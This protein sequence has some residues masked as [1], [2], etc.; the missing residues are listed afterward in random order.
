MTSIL[1]IGCGKMGGALLRGWMQ[2]NPATKVQVIESDTALAQHIQ[3]DISLPV[4]FALRD[5]PADYRPDV[6]VIAFKPQSFEDLLPQLADRF[7]NHSPLYVSIAAGKTL[8]YYETHLG[9]HVSIIRAMPNTPSLIGMGITALCVNRM[10]YHAQ[11]A[12]AE[13]LFIQVGEVVKI[14]NES[15]MDVV[16]AL[17]GS[18]PAYLFLFADAMV[19]AGVALG[20]SEPTARRLALATVRG[21]S[22]LAAQPG[23]SLE[24]L[25][26]NV[27][28]PGGTTESALSVL[29]ENDALK[30]LMK[31]AM[32]KAAARS[33]QLA[34]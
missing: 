31:Q 15:L 34:T 13:T 16:T 20:L 27:T 14:E 23:T 32:E 2:N 17:S 12:L 33:R 22:E 11:A 4:L 9:S 26:K 7:T 28:S 18:G 29:M 24:Q 19:E 3:S 6:V 25:R 1:L 10:V 8:G 5:L 21:S 30:T